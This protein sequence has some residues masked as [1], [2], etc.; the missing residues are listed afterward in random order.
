MSIV[1][2]RTD[3]NRQME[4]VCINNSLLNKHKCIGILFIIL[5]EIKSNII[6][7]YNIISNHACMRFK[8]N[9]NES[10]YVLSVHQNNNL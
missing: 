7:I 1:V 4:N 8:L 6:S 9:L 2:L 5:V 3:W 10:R